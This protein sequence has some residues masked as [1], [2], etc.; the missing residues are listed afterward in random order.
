MARL[1]AAA[2]AAPQHEPGQCYALL[3][4]RAG[5]Q[6]V[7]VCAAWTGSLASSRVLVPEQEGHRCDQSGVWL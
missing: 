3:R 1:A 2:A 7:G 6:L 5:L 4:S